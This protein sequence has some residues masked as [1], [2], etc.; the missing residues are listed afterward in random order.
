MKDE[1]WDFSTNYYCGTFAIMHLI[2]CQSHG[3]IYDI[4]VS[5][6]GEVITDNT[7]I[8]NYNVGGTIEG[9]SL[10]KINI[11]S[12]NKRIAKN[13]LML[14]VRM[15][16]TMAVALYTSRIVLN[17]LGVEDYGIYNVVGGIVVMLSFLNT[18]MSVA[19][20]RFLSYS[21]GQNDKERLSK[22]FCSSV[23][24]HY[25]IAGII[26][27][28]AETVGL[29]FFE[30]YLAIVSERMYAA[31]YVYQF[32]IFTF[33]VN[34][35][36]VPYNACIISHEKMDVYAYVSIV[37]VVLKLIIV[38]ALVYWDYD[39]LILYA[40]LIFIVSLISRLVYQIYCQRNFVECRLKFVWDKNLLKKLISFSGWSLFGGIAYI[41]KS[42]GV[43]I[44]LNIFC[45]VTLN[46]AWGISQQVNTAVLSFIQN[47]GTAL[48]PPIIKAYASDDRDYLLFLF[49]NGMKY[50]FFLSF[51]F[52]LPLLLETEYVMSLWLC[53]VPK[54][55]TLFVRFILVVILL[56]VFAQVV[57][58]VVQAT[59]RIKW[60]Q[61]II[62]SILF[63]NLPLSYFAL[64]MTNDPVSVMYV[65]VLLAL[66]ST[67]VRFWILFTLIRFPLS[68]L[69]LLMRPIVLLCAVAFP[70]MFYFKTFFPIGFIRLLLEIV[71][72]CIFSFIVLVITMSKMERQQIANYV[73][74]K[75]FHRK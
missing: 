66:I 11:V 70:A 44:L 49:F 47:F 38:Y 75:I 71:L 6:K 9:V 57:G 43:N 37:D 33:I 5:G 64:K 1:N 52:I 20:Q 39:K 4:S 69:F 59:G 36:S 16:L 24:I 22:V 40:V 30:H 8:N 7:F 73:Q 58:T 34:V 3:S 13:T 18:A 62:G 54:Y 35:V 25:I 68:R 72:V 14:Y 46:A 29:Y 51:C 17:V 55:T 60:Y 15:L 50:T 74:Q 21:M 65:A 67:V 32:S 27:L 2:G 23:W 12:S 56:E 48:N 42:Q 19:T 26:F 45:G 63:M 53:E 31:A 28:L 61:L 41:A 10:L